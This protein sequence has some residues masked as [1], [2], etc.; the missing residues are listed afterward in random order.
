MKAGSK[1]ECWLRGRLAGG[2]ILW[3][4]KPFSTCSNFVKLQFPQR[5]PECAR[6]QG[7][8][9]TS[10]FGVRLDCCLPPPSP[11]KKKNPLIFSDLTGLRSRNKVRQRQTPGERSGTGL[12]TSHT[13]GR[14]VSLLPCQVS[15]TVSQPWPHPS[16]AQGKCPKGCPTPRNTPTA[17]DVLPL[18]MRT[19]GALGPAAG[20]RAGIYKLD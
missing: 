1:L 14:P 3:P 8:P 9:P 6:A 5:L 15:P 7:G 12:S 16:P 18:E 11:F 20:T 17:Q 10:S 13:A 2:V 4:R 19:L